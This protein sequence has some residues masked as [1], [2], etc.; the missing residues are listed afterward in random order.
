MGI[1]LKLL[2]RIQGEV[3]S[4]RSWNPEGDSGLEVVL[5]TSWQISSVSAPMMTQHTP[6]PPPAPD[7]LMCTLPSPEP[8]RNLSHLLPFIS[9]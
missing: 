5:R 2:N 9:L 1:P 7:G 8:R 3:R 6:L 4:H